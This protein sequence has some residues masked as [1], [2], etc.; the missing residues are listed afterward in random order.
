MVIT[1]NGEVRVGVGAPRIG[2][3]DPVP[4]RDLES[5]YHESAVGRAAVKTEGWG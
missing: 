5:G 4:T 1:R 3:L 2:R